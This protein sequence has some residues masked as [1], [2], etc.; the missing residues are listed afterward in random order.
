MSDAYGSATGTSLFWRVFSVTTDRET[1]RYLAYLLLRFPLGIAYF[2]T[3]VTGLALGLALVPL[4]VGIPLLVF[5]LGVADHAG[6]VEAA[7]LRR[8]LGRETTW[9]PIDPTELPLWPYLKTVATDGRSYLLLVYCL[10]TFW[11]GT[12]S[13][14]LLT[15]CLSVS[16]VYL[17]A[18]LVFWLPGVQY[19]VTSSSEQVVSVGPTTITTSDAALEFLTITTLPEAL[20]GSVLGAAIGILTLHG[21][22]VTGRGL[23]GLTERLLE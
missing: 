18:P 2:T 1:Y 23:A 15:L 9:E 11:I 4:G 10:A 21:C 19:G 13:F 5:V 12:V 14:V 16:V 7:L 8:V 6:L 3:V 20:A 17:I 22:R